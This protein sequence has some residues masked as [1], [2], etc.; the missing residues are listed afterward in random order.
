MHVDWSEIHEEIEHLLAKF[1]E[2][3]L[4]L[5]ENA[6]IAV[7]VVTDH[8]ISEIESFG[9]VVTGASPSKSTVTGLP[10]KLGVD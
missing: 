5:F 8:L 7:E 9:Y 1:S 6:D 4:D 10:S 3:S 2:I